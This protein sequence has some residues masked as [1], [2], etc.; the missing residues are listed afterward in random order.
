MTSSVIDVQQ[1]AQATEPPV[2]V[3]PRRSPIEIF[4]YS[5]L[6]ASIT[7]FAAIRFHLRQVPLERDEGEYAYMGQLMLQ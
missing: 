3:S 5:L 2:P 7:L 6:I 1:Q 4:S